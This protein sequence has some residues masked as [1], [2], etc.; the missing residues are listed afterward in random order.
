V[1]CQ[2]SE[3]L[4]PVPSP[5]KQTRINMIRK[6]GVWEANERKEYSK[7]PGIHAHTH[8]LLANLR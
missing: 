5:P 7:Q 8:V 2:G 6:V 4:P 1:H 3:L